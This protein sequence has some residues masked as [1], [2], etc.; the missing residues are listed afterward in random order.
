M[1]VLDCADPSMRVEKRNQSISALQALAFLNNGFM[2]TQARHFAAR[3]EREAG[4]DSAAQVDT[5]MRL[6]LGR[7]ATADERAALVPLTEAHGLANTCRAILNLNE[8]SFV[9]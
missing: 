9:D 2:T 3:V 8:F 4:S 7:P 5:A 6:A 1:T